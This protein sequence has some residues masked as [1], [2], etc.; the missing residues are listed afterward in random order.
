VAT[1]GQNGTGI[2][3]AA[4][5]DWTATGV[6]VRDG[7]TLFIRSSGEIR[8]N[9]SDRTTAAGIGGAR[10]GAGFPLPSAPAGALIGRI[11]NGQPF[12]IGNQASV[13]MPDA[14]QLFL[15]INDDVVSDNS[16]EFQVTISNVR[17]R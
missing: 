5:Q 17:R 14:G 4:N 3:V 13:R 2:R 16:G 9:D 7:E 15:G 12:L 10:R 8:L 1:S 6:T 11:D